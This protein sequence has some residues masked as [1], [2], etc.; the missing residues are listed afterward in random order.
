MIPTIKEKQWLQ[1]YLNKALRYRETYDEIYDHI[2]TA[3]EHE[4]AAEFFETTVYN[5]IEK[6][7]GG[8][9]NMLYMEVQS[10]RAISPE[11]KMQYR[12]KFTEWFKLPLVAYTLIITAFNFYFSGSKHF[13]LG[14]LSFIIFL[15]PILIAVVRKILVRFKHHNYK[16]SIKEGAFDRLL[17]RD[18]LLNNWALAPLISM[19]VLVA[20]N[21]LHLYDYEIIGNL[22]YKLIISS[23]YALIVINNLSVIQVYLQDIKTRKAI[24]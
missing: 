2:L 16:P 20:K 9:N 18:I 8:S 23:V 22:I 21:M 17:Y 1:D 13:L 4:S 24:S 10:K 11:I 6:E 12:R 7:F 19:I 14:M 3:L 15:S 5:V